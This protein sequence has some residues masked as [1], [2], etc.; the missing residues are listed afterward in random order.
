[1]QRNKTTP[2]WGHCSACDQWF[3][4]KSGLGQ[5]ESHRH[6]V[7]QNGKRLKPAPNVKGKPGRS[8]RVWS[9]KEVALLRELEVRYA[10]CQFINKSIASILKTK[11]PKQT[12][13]KR[14]L[15]AN[16]LTDVT[17]ISESTTGIDLHNSEAESDQENSEDQAQR[18]RASRRT[19]AWIPKH[20]DVDYQLTQ[21]EELLSARYDPDTLA[22]G[23]GLVE[24]ITDLL[25]N[26]R[27]R[28]DKHKRPQKDRAKKDKRPSSNTGAKKWWAARKALFRAT[29]QLYKTNRRQLAHEIMGAPTSSA[30][31]LSKEEL[32]TCFHEKLSATNKKSNINKYAPYTG[33]V[34][35]RSLMKPIEV[36]EVEVAIKGIEANS[37]AGPDDLK[38]QDIRTIHEQEET[39]LPCL[40]SLWLKSSMIPNSLKK[41]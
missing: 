9:Q 13:D 29:Q 32:E 38:L 25:M 41:S 36:E 16:T 28:Q 4:T 3:S 15:L 10:G 37:A 11:T 24:S 20:R 5:H 17:A 30:C 12:S 40:F 34:N 1:M 22:L 8:D 21:A 23:I 31:P 33:K 6:P 7:L 35:D 18:Q 39:C 26:S 2:N 14:R 19:P 27:K